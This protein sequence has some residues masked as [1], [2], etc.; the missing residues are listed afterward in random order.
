MV[1]DTTNMNGKSI[2]ALGPLA[3]GL[4]LCAP[5]RAQFGAEPAELE[6]IQLRD[7]IYVISNPAVPG[8]VTALITDE[9]VLLVDDKFEIDHDN[10]HCHDQQHRTRSPRSPRAGDA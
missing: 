8:L 10:P 4:L 5:A 9:G 1:G 7:D 3:L 2:L 6:L